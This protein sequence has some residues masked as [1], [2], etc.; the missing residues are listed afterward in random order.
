MDG[1]EPPLDGLRAAA[2]PGAPE[3]DAAR[4]GFHRAFP[5]RSAKRVF[6]VTQLLALGALSAVVVWAFRSVPALS[7]EVLH[8]G[9]LVVFACAIF[10]RL[11]AAGSLKRPLW[12]IADPRT[13]PTYTVLCPLFREANVVPDLVASLNALD[14]PKHALDV[15]LLVEGDDP[16]TIAAA[17]SAANGPH[18]EVVIIPVAVPRTKPKALNIGLARARGEFVVVYDAEDRPH[19]QQLRA[20]LAAFEESEPALACLQAPLVIDNA[21]QSW[22]ARQFAAEYAIQF[23]EVLPLL[24]RMHMPLALGGSS[25]HFRVEALR[26][27]GGW[28]A[29]NVSECEVAFAA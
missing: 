17:L 16:E 18:I 2:S 5:H 14:Y 29:Y 1:A 9:G 21:E 4:Y 24:A 12:R 19:A 28:D 6:Y 25:N 15:K 3:L 11:I 20:A 22:I 13:F 27:A 26:Q 8:V 23:R 7:W 10:F